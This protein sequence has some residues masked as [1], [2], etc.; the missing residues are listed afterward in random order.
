MMCKNCKYH[1]DSREGRFLI[2][3]GKCNVFPTH[4]PTEDSHYCGQFEKK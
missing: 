3:L 4:K 2:R 1:T